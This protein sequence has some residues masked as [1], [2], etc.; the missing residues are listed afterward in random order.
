MKAGVV[1][2]PGSNCDQDLAKAFRE[3]FGLKTVMLWHKDTDLQDCDIIGLPGGFSYGDYLRT[4]AIAKISPIMQSVIAFAN[5]GGRVIGI[6]N[7]FQILTESGL[8][9]GALVKNDGQLFRCENVY[10]SYTGSAL[11]QGHLEKNKGYKIPIAHSEGRFIATEDTLKKL[12]QEHRIVFKYADKDGNV[13]QEA[14][15]NGSMLNIAGICNRE[16]NVVGM[17][18]HPERASSSLLGNTD[19]FAILEACLD[20]ISA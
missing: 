5:K 15:P 10:I 18:P 4:G 9:E 12:E 7:G 17:M 3:S 6:C 11:M 1:V 16:G 8:L 14:N 20:L 19:G 2:F 13:T